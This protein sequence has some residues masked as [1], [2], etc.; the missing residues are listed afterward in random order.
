MVGG[1]RRLVSSVNCEPAALCA[2]EVWMAML[3]ACK[4][5]LA[6]GSLEE[7]MEIGTG[8]GRAWGLQ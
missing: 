2:A 6:L 8:E 3:L 4:E 7:L 5:A 1:R